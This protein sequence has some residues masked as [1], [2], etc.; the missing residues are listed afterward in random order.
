MLRVSRQNP[1]RPAYKPSLHGIHGVN[2]SIYAGG[3]DIQ[4]FLAAMGTYNHD[5]P[6][7]TDDNPSFGGWRR[8][9]TD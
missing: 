4:N 8:L 3:R 5:L 2:L 6:L 1:A 7:S 9:A